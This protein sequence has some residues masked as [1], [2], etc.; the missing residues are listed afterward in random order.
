MSHILL[1]EDDLSLIEGLEYSLSRNGFTTDV[2]RTAK[3][4]LA[5][6]E[7]GQYDLILLDLT[8]PDGNGFSICKAVRQWSD[9]PIIF[10]TAADEEVNIVMGLDLGGDDYVT[11]PFKLT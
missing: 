6:L 10:L 11:K 1:V 2:K 4:A 9:V 3:E 8:L 5:A 7:R